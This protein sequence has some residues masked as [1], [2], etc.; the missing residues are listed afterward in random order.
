MKINGIKALDYQDQGDRL[1]L[2]L[3]GTTLEEIAGMDT[4]LLR[5]TTDAGDLVD[6]FAGYKVTRVA[7]DVATRAYTATLQRN[8][9]DTVARALSA[10][11]DQLQRVETAQQV[12][13]GP[14]TAAAVAFAAIA[15]EI[16]DTMAL[17]MPSLFPTWDEV[18]AAGQL[19]PQGRIIEK[20][21]VL[22]RVAQAG[23]VTPQAHQVPGGDG[24]LAVYRP[25]DQG[26]AGT[27]D[28][29]IP[30]VYGMDCSTGLYYSYEGAIYKCAGD[31]KPCTWPPDTADPSFWQ[32]EKIK[33]V[34]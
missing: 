8:V 29:P 17:E 25:I 2:T 22:Y 21:G 20:D 4:A 11:T 34:N 10:V 1:V 15:T 26:H 31:M 13:A 28:D 9:D 6:A 12:V 33:E 5:V 18:L 27:E 16:P 19:I 7:Y 30:W 24:M 14:V 23:G 3:S 32:W